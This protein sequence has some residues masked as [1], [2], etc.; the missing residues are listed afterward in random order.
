[1]LAQFTVE[2]TADGIAALIRRLAKYGDPE[3]VQVGTEHPNG[4][5]VDLLLEA[6]HSV[7][8]VS[9]SAIKIWRESEVVSGAKSDAGNAMVIAEFLR[10]RY[11]QLHLVQPY[12][13]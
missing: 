9:P 3:V 7:I 5:L 1:M 12:S 4:R 11:H 8:P 6:G 10:L 13:S 2:H